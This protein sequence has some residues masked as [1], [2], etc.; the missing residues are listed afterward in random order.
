[1]KAYIIFEI[2]H[3]KKNGSKDPGVLYLGW[4]E[5]YI[6]SSTCT[7]VYTSLEWGIDE[8]GGQSLACDID[9]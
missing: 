5:T 1:M 9:L 8:E 6:L 7:F 2:C 3:K 4:A